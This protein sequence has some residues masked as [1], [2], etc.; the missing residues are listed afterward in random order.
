MGGRCRSDGT[1][2][3]NRSPFGLRDAANHGVAGAAPCC[4]AASTMASAAISSL[5]GHG[6]AVVKGSDWAAG[7]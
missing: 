3:A 2:T 4:N 7:S 1:R 5:S 6:A